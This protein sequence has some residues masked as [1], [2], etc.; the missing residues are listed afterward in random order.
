MYHSR[1]K[2]ETTEGQ[3]QAHGLCKLCYR[4]TKKCGLPE[5][6]NLIMAL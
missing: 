3:L 4:P 1:Q 5:L 6:L 2:E